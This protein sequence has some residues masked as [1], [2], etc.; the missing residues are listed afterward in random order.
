[1]TDRSAFE[2]SVKKAETAA[3]SSPQNVSR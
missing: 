3:A 2:P 1:M